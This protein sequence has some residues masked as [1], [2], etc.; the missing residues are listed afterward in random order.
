MKN[1]GTNIRTPFDP[2]W[3]RATYRT[4]GQWIRVRLIP[5]EPRREDTCTAGMK[6]GG[7]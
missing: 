7:Q 6:R 3:V 1:D 4:T 5:V 2:A